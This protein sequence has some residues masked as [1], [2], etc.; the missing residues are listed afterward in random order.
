MGIINFPDFTIKKYLKY[1]FDSTKV[2]LNSFPNILEMGRSIG[3]SQQLTKFLNLAPLELSL[4]LTF[5][6]STNFFYS[7]I[8]QIELSLSLIS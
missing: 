8:V 4:E 3:F 2:L 7:N 6:L 5:T 1:H